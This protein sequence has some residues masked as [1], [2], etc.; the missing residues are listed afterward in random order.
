MKSHILKLA[1]MMA[2]ILTCGE[3]LAATLPRGLVLFTEPPADYVQNLEFVTLTNTSV[4]H[5]TAVLS[6]GRKQEIPR[7]GIVAVIPYPPEVASPSHS[8]D[9]AAGLQA[10]KVARGKYPQF[11]AKLDAAQA[12]WS[13]SLE[14]FR[15]RQRMTK[16]ALP[17]VASTLSLEIEGFTY[18]QAVLTSFDGV[19]V[20]IAHEAG[21]ARIPAIK[22]KP[23]QITGLNATSSLVRIDPKAITDSPPVTKTAPGRS[24]L[25]A[26][27]AQKGQIPTSWEGGT[28]ATLALARAIA[29][30]FTSAPNLAAG[31]RLAIER[32]PGIESKD[33]AYAAIL[34]DQLAKARSHHGIDNERFWSLFLE[35]LQKW[36]EARIPGDCPDFLVK[37]FLAALISVE[38]TSARMGT[39]LEWNSEGTRQ[40]VL[41][42][43]RELVWAANRQELRPVIALGSLIDGHPW[44]ETKSLVLTDGSFLGHRITELQKEVA[45]EHCIAIQFMMEG[46]LPKIPSGSHLS[47]SA[48]LSKAATLTAL[49]FESAYNRGLLNNL[50]TL[51][52][53]SFRFALAG[54]IAGLIRQSRVDVPTELHDPYIVRELLD[55]FP[56][57]D[58]LQDANEVAIVIGKRLPSLPQTAKARAGRV[59][60]ESAQIATREAVN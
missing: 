57:L 6:S 21:A 18:A 51:H 31:Q 5:A 22:L 52:S 30:C 42:H 27:T 20:G 9:A 48:V 25:S 10:I 15:Q 7:V 33:P 41:R 19:T 59:F 11:A 58:A 8:Q 49:D 37:E 43:F 45:T 2:T 60:A 50:A 28:P 24:E 4:V 38:V 34:L 47:Q 53:R 40:M 39:A 54:R 3:T 16:A 1:V 44:E 26:M 55:E 46:L 17:P 36:R 35:S 12:R 32:I 23:E 14:V 56:T 13:N 29:D